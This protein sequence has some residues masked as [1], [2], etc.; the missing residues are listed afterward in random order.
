M[1]TSL[2]V[3]TAIQDGGLVRLTFNDGT[4]FAIYRNDGSPRCYADDLLDAW[5]ENGN[6]ITET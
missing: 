3:V 2:A 6:E 1:E 4:E 5:L